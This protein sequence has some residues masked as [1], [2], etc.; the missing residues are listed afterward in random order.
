MKKLKS[1]STQIKGAKERLEFKGKPAAEAKARA[2]D[3][4]TDRFIAKKTGTRLVK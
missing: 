2:M 3:R 1:A 4:K